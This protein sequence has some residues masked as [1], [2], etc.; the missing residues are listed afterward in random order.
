M[1]QRRSALVALSSAFSIRLETWTL[2]EQAFFSNLRRRD[3]LKL[4]I[5][6]SP[7]CCAAHVVQELKGLLRSRG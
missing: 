4:Y 1:Q 3:D 2:F 7:E 6:V 5:A